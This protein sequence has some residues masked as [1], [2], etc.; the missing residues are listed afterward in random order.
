MAKSLFKV[1]TKVS[2]NL[3]RVE[4]ASERSERRYLFRVGGYA[5]KVAKSLLVAR[6][7]KYA[8]PGESPKGKTGAMRRGMAFRVEMKERS[9]IIGPQRDTSKPNTLKLH[10]YGGAVSGA[11]AGYVP[12]PKSAVRS[13]EVSEEYPVLPSNKR[14]HVRV[15]LPAGRRTYA[16]RP[17]MAPAL[18]RTTEQDQTKF[19][20]GA[21]K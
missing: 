11:R 21:S 6:K 5:L 10:E 15:F 8:K 18:K 16:P 3:E 4:K 17:Y 13:G 14:A 1:A 9:V 19:W 12:I 20:V 2:L 7:T